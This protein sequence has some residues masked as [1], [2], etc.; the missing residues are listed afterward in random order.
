[1]TQLCSQNINITP[2]NKSIF[3]LLYK[4]MRENYDFISNNRKCITG[5]LFLDCISIQILACRLWFNNI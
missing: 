4:F 2:L 1:M 3:N 5:L